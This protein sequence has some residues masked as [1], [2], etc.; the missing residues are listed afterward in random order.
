MLQYKSSSDTPSPAGEPTAPLERRPANS[1]R[2]WRGTKRWT[3]WLHVYSSM[4]ALL[5]VLFFGAT[6]ITLNHP[7]WTFGLDST[8]ESYAGFLPDSWLDQSGEIEFLVISE[9]LRETY[10]V[11]GQVSDYGSDATTGFISY[12]GPGYSAA[13]FFDPES[14][15]YELT[16][17]EQGFVAVLNDLHKGRDTDS[18]WNWLIDASGVLLIAIALTGLGLQLFMKKR[19]TSAL[20]V[21]G[22]GVLAAVVLASVS[23]S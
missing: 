21:V 5:V 3:R 2:G 8:T 20:V 16:I 12:A 22:V 15:E 1:V 7:E 6:G 10:D 19:R 17:E 13:V 14:G 18:S 4:I 23:I 11:D 9:F